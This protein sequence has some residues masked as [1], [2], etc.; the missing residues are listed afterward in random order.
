M[1][2]CYL[3]QESLSHV[4]RHARASNVCIAGGEKQ[5][6]Y[7]LEVRDNGV[8]FNPDLRKKE[9]FGL[10]GIRERAIILGGKLDYTLHRAAV[11]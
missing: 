3:T 9:S 7:V 11:R 6:H 8:G 10:V 1:T 4:R 2:D 5:M